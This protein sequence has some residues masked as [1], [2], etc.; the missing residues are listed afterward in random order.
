MTTAAPPTTPFALRGTLVLPT[1]VVDDGVVV[2]D[3]DRFVWAGPADGAPA[4]LAPSVAAAATV[5]TILPGLVDLHCH[6][7]GGAS[8]PD[9]L[10]G[11]TALR[12]VAEHRAH[13]TTTLV[14]SLV[15]A[16]PQTLV[17]RTAL[18]A[19]L[20]QAGEVD[21]I[22]LEGP[23]LSRARCGAQNPA[24]MTAGDAELVR[25]VA[26]A[27]RGFLAT[28]TIAPE[29][30]GVLGRGGVL[31][32]LVESGALPSIGHTDASAE[33]VEQALGAAWSALRAPGA[34][35]RRPTAT[36]LFN[37]MRPLHHRDPGPV[38]AC[39]AAAARGQAVVELV[40]DGV[41]L[42]PETVRAVFDLVGPGAIALVTDAMAATGMPD[43]TY[44][45]GPVHVR[46]SGGVARLAD[47]DAIA[48]GT[49]HL[50]DVVRSV[51]AAGVPLVDAVL[52]ASGTPAAVLGRDDVGAL[53]T[54]R[55]ADLVVVDGDLR[56]QRVLRAGRWVV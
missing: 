49:A 37:G 24:L 40:A 41:H 38:A 23:F 51:V 34:R 11:P 39:L 20:A 36:H 48:G 13:G 2:V 45:L 32:A 46:V 54:G 29:V 30:A 15:T 50:L 6:G 26:R 31:E 42:A 18:L 52:A 10:D 55:R 35:S 43:G 47:G 19:E 56:P 53:A 27:G 12:G 17:D 1:T 28:M 3:G 14:A 33:V 22:H 8:F 5:G 44:E 7:G 16:D 21:G 25:E 4:E 9:A